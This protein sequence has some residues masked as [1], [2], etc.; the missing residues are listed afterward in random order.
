LNRRSTEEAVGRGIEERFRGWG[1]VDTHARRAHGVTLFED[2]PEA[3]RR[4]KRGQS[5]D[6]YQL[7]TTNR[8]DSLTGRTYVDLWMVF[9]HERNPTSNPN[10]DRLRLLGQ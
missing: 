8:P 1:Y 10:A 3:K 7:L 5:N 6:S 9:R 4:C 2:I